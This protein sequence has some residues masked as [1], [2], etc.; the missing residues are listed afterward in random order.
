MGASIAATTLGGAATVYGIKKNVPKE[1]ILALAYFTLM[2]LLQVAQYMWIGQCDIRQNQFLTYL[3]FIH[4]CFQI[5]VA[6]M[7][8]LSFASK[9]A[10]KRWTKPVVLISFLASFFLLAKVVAPWVYDIPKEWMCK[11][12]DAL[13]GDNACT[14]KG[15]WH[16][17]WRMPLLG[18]DPGNSIY[19]ILVFLLP[20]VYGSW[21]ISL[22]HF[23]V[24]PL[25]AKM[26]SNDHNE[27]PAIWCLFSIG[28]LCAIFFTPLKR[29]FE[30]PMREK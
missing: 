21:R 9:N 25:F 14:Y 27:V 12:G 6:N 7:F 5:P 20:L 13:C 17:S 10:R 8:M 2:E 30:T 29:W 23:M 1:R 24:G 3:G 18:Y 22:F 16:L 28:I 15:N 26:L 4:I 19:F 11:V